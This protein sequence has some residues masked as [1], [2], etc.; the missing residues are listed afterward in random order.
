MTGYFELKYRRAQ[1]YLRHPS[2]TSTRNI[3]PRTHPSSHRRVSC[4]ILYR[5]PTQ[6]S[7]SFDPRKKESCRDLVIGT[8]VKSRDQAKRL[9]RSYT[10]SIIGPPLIWHSGSLN[11]FEVTQ[12]SREMAAVDTRRGSARLERP[13]SIVGGPVSGMLHRPSLVDNVRTASRDSLPNNNTSTNFSNGIPGMGEEKPIASGNGV[14]LSIA[15]AEPVLFLQGFDQSELGNQNTTMLRGNFRVRVS[16]S[17]KIK[18]VSLAF[19]GRAETEWPEGQ[20]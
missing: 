9:L 3:S 13:S 11:P 16:K 15:L 17:A 4:Q 2:G 7:V 19:R 5:C 18:T 10:P 14:A 12:S 8:A 1:H 20:S 6:S